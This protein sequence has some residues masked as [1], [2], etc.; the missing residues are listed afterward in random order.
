MSKGS[1][2]TY[3]ENIERGAGLRS[4]GVRVHP[5]I[6]EARHV[7]LAQAIIRETNLEG[8]V[9]LHDHSEAVTEHGRGPQASE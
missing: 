9:V 1:V 2:S 4:Q 6:G 5:H 3:L 7:E 8:D